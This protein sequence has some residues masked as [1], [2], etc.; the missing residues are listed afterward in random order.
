[1]ASLP[2]G[3]QQISALFHCVLSL[4]FPGLVAGRTDDP[5][6][7]CSLVSDVRHAV[8]RGAPIVDAVA[9]LQVVNVPAEL[10]L[11]VSRQHDQELFRI[12]VRI[13]LCAGG[14]TDVEL[15]HEHLEVMQWTRGEQ[16]LRAQ[17]P[18]PER[19]TIVSSEHL[20]PRRPA[21]V[22]QVGDAHAEGTGD[23]SERRDARAR[24]AALDLAQEALAD[25]GALRDRPERRAPE[26]ANVPQS[27]ADVDFDSS[28][29]R[30]G[31]DQISLDP[32]EGKLK[33]PYGPD[34][35]VS[36]AYSGWHMR[37]LRLFR[38]GKRGP[39][40]VASGLVRRM[41]RAVTGAART[42]TSIFGR[43]R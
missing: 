10:E 9:S 27:L 35:A 2:K 29:G 33:R 4:P 25:A 7:L 18:E 32:V 15:A 3:G 11:N 22:E 26:A 34:E 20:G 41:G 42:A 31:R 23:P 17:D 38:R 1:M 6:H 19:R 8:R 37:P 40:R 30:A 12:S 21:R 16:L 5:D 36:T 39:V 24:A 43:S 14:P 13:R 28:F